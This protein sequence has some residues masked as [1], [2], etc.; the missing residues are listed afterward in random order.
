MR[1][2]LKNELWKK[3]VKRDTDRQKMLNGFLTMAAKTTPQLAANIV[4]IV[5]GSIEERER[6]IDSLE[7]NAERKRVAPSDK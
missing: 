2:K 1:D 6:F 7:Q 4:M 5:S 3:C